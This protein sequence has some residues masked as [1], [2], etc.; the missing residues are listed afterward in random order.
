VALP[1]EVRIAEATHAVGTWGTTLIQIWRGPSNGSAVTAMIRVGTE[2]VTTSRRPTTSLFVV[3]PSS[4]PPGD[5]ARRQLAIFSRDVVSRMALAVVVPE[6]SGFRSAIVRAVGVTLTTLLPHTSSFKFVNDTEEASR[7]LAPHLPPE[8]GG[9]A[10]LLIAVEE[11][12]AR[13]GEPVSR[14]HA[15][16]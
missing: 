1:L 8:S 2:L 12:R 4:P 10:R 13:I 3:E 14:S 9:R 7:L 16:F 6:G 15:G 5:E 11:L